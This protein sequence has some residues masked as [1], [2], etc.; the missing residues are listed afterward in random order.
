[1]G[2]PQPNASSAV[3]NSSGFFRL[4]TELAS[5][6]D[7]YESDESCH[8]I[9]LGPES[10]ISVVNVNYFDPDSPGFLNQLA[11]SS[12]RSFTANLVARNDATYAPFN[13]PGRILFWPADIYDPNYIPTPFD[14]DEDKINNIT[15]ILDVVQYFSPIPSLIPQRIDKA[16]EI[17]NYDAVGVN[18]IV[19]PFYGR[20][21]AYVEFSAKGGGVQPS[22]IQIIGTN[23]AI[24][25]SE[26]VDPVA[27]TPYHQEVELLAQTSVSPGDPAVVKII[28]ATA[29][30]AFDA[31]VIGIHS[32]G[33]APLRVVTSDTL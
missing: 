11:V 23:Y 7:I 24:T 32:G 20:K 28:T 21:Y 9:S 1:M 19:I 31:L 22:T 30:G 29:T 14:P 12:Q 18:W 13:T 16:Y 3:A 8:A 27:G 10:D 17:Q 15:P 33:P 26:E 5:P 4:R 25:P 6:G 2:Y